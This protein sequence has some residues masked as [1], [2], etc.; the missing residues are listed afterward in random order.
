MLIPFVIITGVLLQWPLIS[1]TKESYKHAAEK[2]ATLIE[3]LTG[4]EAVK[5]IGA[6]SNLQSRWENTTKAAS[7]I[8]LRLRMFSNLGINLTQLAQQ[9]ATIGVVIFGVYAI[10]EG[11][12]TTGALIACTI[13]TGRALAPMSQVASLLTRWYQSVNALHSLDKVMQMPTDRENQQS[14]LHRPNFVGRLECKDLNFSYPEEQLPALTNIN[15]KINA[16]ERVG[17]IGR[18]GSGKTT[19]AKLIAGLYQPSEGSILLDGTDLQQVDPSDLRQNMGYVNQDVMLFYGSVKDNITFGAPFVDDKNIL[20]AAK[21]AGVDLFTNHHPQGFDM[22]VGERGM[23]LSGGQRQ[24]I[25]IARALLLDPHIVVMDEPTNAM[26]DSTE[27]YLRMQLGH[28]IQ[29]KTF[30]LITHKA[31]ML[32]L[33]DRLIVVDDGKIV[34]DGPKTEVIAQLSAG[35]IHGADHMKG[36]DNASE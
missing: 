15:L 26:D 19:L 8:G 6:E 17:I 18:I 22:Q 24:S 2:Q 12:M 31:S 36:A 14:F 11:E 30:I 34:A 16:G 21:V 27:A 29:G 23:Q 25:S 9:L 10:A 13:L 4:A 7:K 28:Y 20:R 1:L 5:S 32:A 3:S 35:K 33:V